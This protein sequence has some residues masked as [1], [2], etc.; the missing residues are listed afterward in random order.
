MESMMEEFLVGCKSACVLLRGQ[1]VNHLGL[2]GT[3]LT[4]LDGKIGS[5]G[6]Q[7]PDS[8]I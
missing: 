2:W 7:R 4:S 8:K 3:D 5:G 6:P 1:L